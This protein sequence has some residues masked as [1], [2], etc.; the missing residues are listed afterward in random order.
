MT[1]RRAIFLDRDGV[2]NVNRAD[3]VKS[4][5]EFV[6]LPGALEALRD[7]A[8]SE[9]V[10]I[11]TTNQAAIARGMTSEVVVRDIH[12]RMSTAIARAGGRVDAIY[13]C[14]HRPEDACACRK[15]ETGMYRDAARAL[16]ID[17]TRS[18]VI[19]DAQADVDAARAIG[20]QG[21]LV[22]TGRGGEHHSQMQACARNDYVVV[23]DLPRAVEWIRQRE[24]WR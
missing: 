13:F 23:A 24:T 22:L 5:D 8:A 11:V 19:G 7:L 2:I 14:P 9:F 18:Y 17:T 16:G 12:A 3:H 10:I 4:W 6:F 15:P 20:A 1:T 21:I